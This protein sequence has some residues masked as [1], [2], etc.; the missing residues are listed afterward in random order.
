[1][2]GLLFEKLDELCDVI[3]NDDK[4]IELLN[5]KKQIY[6]DSNLKEKLERYQNSSNK[7]DTV[8]IALKSDIINDPLVKR[9]R[10]LENE[11]YFLVLEINSKLN[12]LIEKKGCSNENN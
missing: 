10:K 12:S 5:L 2:N 6:K 11:L 7:Y 1:M 9:Y 3:D 8:F 4:V